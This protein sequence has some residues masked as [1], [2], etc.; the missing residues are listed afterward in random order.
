MRKLRLG[1]L[2]EVPFPGGDVVLR[3]R[4]LPGR[5][6][7]L[8]LDVVVGALLPH[9]DLLNKLLELDIMLNP[10]VLLGQGGLNALDPLR[11]RTGDFRQFV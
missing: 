4:R 3:D 11:R 9:V 6:S 10:L 5:F 1:R 2:R 7:D 8:F